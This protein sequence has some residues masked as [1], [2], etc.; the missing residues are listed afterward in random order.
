MVVQMDMIALPNRC[1]QRQAPGTAEAAAVSGHQGAVRSADLVVVMR[2]LADGD[3]VIAR[4]RLRLVDL[5]ITQVERR[6][7]FHQRPLSGPV[8]VHCAKGRAAAGEG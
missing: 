5:F 8:R 1:A 6:A 4:K 2:N 3:P 7:C